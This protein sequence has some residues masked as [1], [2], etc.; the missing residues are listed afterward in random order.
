[1]AWSYIPSELLQLRPVV[2][3]AGLAAPESAIYA[4]DRSLGNIASCHI[5]KWLDVP[6]KI[7]TLSAGMVEIW[8]WCSLESSRKQTRP[9]TIQGLRETI[10]YHS[11]GIQLWKNP[12][13]YSSYL[14][15]WIWYRSGGINGGMVSS[16]WTIRWGRAPGFWWQAQN[17]L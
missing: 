16:P 11:R 12:T 5:Y 13:R 6:Q 8:R 17:C 4:M 10:W 14:S 7:I 3:I 9:Y 1:M 15:Y 2:C